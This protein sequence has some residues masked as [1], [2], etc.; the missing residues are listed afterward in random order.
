MNIYAIK[1]HKRGYFGALDS[2]TYHIIEESIEQAIE[3][4]KPEIKS[5]FG[6]EME[7][8]ISG[9]EEIARDVIIPRSVLKTFQA[10][11]SA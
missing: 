9:A 1:F 3:A 6:S 10:L 5:G 7:Y 2:Y 8:D 11:K 4:V